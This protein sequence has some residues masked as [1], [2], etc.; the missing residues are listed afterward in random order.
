MTAAKW[1]DAE[2]MTTHELLVELLD[3]VAELGKRLK[4]ADRLEIPCEDPAPTG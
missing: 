1:R 2:T 4:A 3:L